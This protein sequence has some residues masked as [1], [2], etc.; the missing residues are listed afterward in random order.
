MWWPHKTLGI[1]RTKLSMKAERRNWKL[2]GLQTMKWKSEIKV[3]LTRWKYLLYNINRINRL[4]SAETFDFTLFISVYFHL[5]LHC[6]KSTKQFHISVWS[7]VILHLFIKSLCGDERTWGRSLERNQTRK[8]T[9]PYLDDTR[10]KEREGKRWLGMLVVIEWLRPVYNVLSASRSSGR[11]SY[12]LFFFFSLK[13]VHGH[14]SLLSV[15]I[16]AFL[17]LLLNN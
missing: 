10:E 3:I 9:R 1:R 11:T 6:K 2:F 16:P 4:L 5:Y 8:V 12:E 15:Y 14:T 13:A 7:P 17:S